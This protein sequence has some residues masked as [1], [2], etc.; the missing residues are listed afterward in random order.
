MTKIISGL[1]DIIHHYDVILS[2]IWGVLWN[3]TDAYPDAIEVLKQLKDQEKRVILISNAP[4]SATWVSNMLSRAG[5]ERQ[6]YESIVTS[7]V[8]C[9][10]FL[11]SEPNPD[12]KKYMMIG[13][14][15]DHEY[16]HNIPYEQTDLIEKADFILLISLESNH[17]SLD[18]YM[19]LL[20]QAQQRQL[21]IICAN[22]DKCFIDAQGH[23][24]IRAGSIAQHYQQ[25]LQGN[26]YYFGKPHQLIYR[27]CQKQ[28]GNNFNASK[29]LAIGDSIEHDVMGAKTFGIDSLLVTTGVSQHL[30]LDECQSMALD[31]VSSKLLWS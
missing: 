13:R 29:T 17:S 27:A 10:D 2:D 14:E 24:M 7:G 21:P 11:K 28:I 23:S 31:Y 4:K 1:K 9:Y 5:I 8:V 18:D 25:Q 30:S 3:G 12:W 15:I 6:W 22:P 19:P 26:V 16:Y 20:H